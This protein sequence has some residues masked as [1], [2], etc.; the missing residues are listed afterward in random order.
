LPDFNTV[1]RAESSLFDV[2]PEGLEATSDDVVL[3]DPIVVLRLRLTSVDGAFARELAVA[4]AID[5]DVLDELESS[6]SSSLRFSD[7][8]LVE[9]AP[10]NVVL[11]VELV[12]PSSSS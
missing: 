3:L 1:S 8:M 4:N 9:V 5:D 11:V 10:V 12:R 7:L 6:S 2:S